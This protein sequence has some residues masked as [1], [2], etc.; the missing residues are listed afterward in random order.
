MTSPLVS[1]LTAQFK[2]MYARDPGLLVQAPGRVNLIGEH[3]D[4]NGGF[5]LPCAIDFHTLVAVSG[6]QDRWVRVAAMDFDGQ[7]DEFSLD[8]PILPSVD[9]P[10]ANYVRGVVQIMLAQGLPLCGAEMAILGN[11]PQGAGLSSSASLEVAVAKAFKSLCGINHLSP[12][13]LALIG[14][15]AENQF[16]GCQ[17]GI[18]D[19]LISARGQR[20]HA[21]LIDCRNLLTQAV[22]MPTDVAVMIIHSRIQRG[23][24]ESEYNIRR[25]Q[26][27][28]AARHY[29]VTALRDLDF[30]Q[31]QLGAAGLDDVSYRRARHVVTENQRT[32]DSANA[33]ASNDMTLMG[34]LMA[35]SHQSM[36]DD[37]QITVPALD[38]L[39]T[40][41]QIA[42]GADGGARM[43]GGGFGGC[44]V[45]L[46]PVEKVPKVRHAI[47]TNYR[48][49]NG[50]SA[51]VN[52]CT[53]SE[54]AS[55]W[56]PMSL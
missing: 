1:T 44:V 12:T 22:P 36:C 3:T 45:A 4:Y 46:V 41:A 5:V 37:F 33:L 50:E 51:H 56:S 30:Q 24:V 38:A 10:W 31:L 35:Q 26:C 27:E 54:G 28:K 8:G 20:G 40:I 53:P 15:R 19:Q 55:A 39:V 43:T 48:A 29:G 13:D 49:P 11:V 21:L 23:L 9:K 25:A 2:R 6:R 52:V 17:C 32:L 47:E 7:M 14:Q 16:V 34:Q 42:I 18:M